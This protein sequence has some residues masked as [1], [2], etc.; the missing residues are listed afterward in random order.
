M[1]AHPALT[2]DGLVKTFDLGFLGALPGFGWLAARLGVKGIAHRVHAVQGVT[3]SVEPGEIYGFLGPNGA[4]KTTT[5]K[6]LMGLIHPTAG[7][8]TLLGRPL[9]DRE[10]RARLGFLPEHPYFYD[11]L[12]PQEF[13]EFYGQL[14]R[15]GARERRDRARALIDRVGLGYAA[16]RPLRRFSKGMIQRIGI[17]QALINDPDLV[18]LDEPMSG[19]DPMG[20]KD[21]RD[22][23]FELKQRG[24]TVFFSSHILQDVEMI[25]DR[26]GMVVRGKVV[27]EGPLHALLDMP[28]H[29]IEIVLGDIDDAVVERLAADAPTPTRVGTQWRFAVESEAEVGAFVRDAIAAGARLVSVTPQRRSLEEVFVARAQEGDAR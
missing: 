12:K 25:C 22:I 20:R 21:V 8:G 23:I 18:V 11:H 17:A 26:V 9:G 27:S 5:M 28:S 16:D 6:M 7:T 2:V 10:A 1:S 15:L 14:F 3:L 13:L 24:K 19:L 4:G 29:R